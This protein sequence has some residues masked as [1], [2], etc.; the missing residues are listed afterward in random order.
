MYVNKAH[1]VSMNAQ[2]AEQL[3]VAKVA[4]TLSRSTEVMKLVR[5]S[6]QEILTLHINFRSK[7]YNTFCSSH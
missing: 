1:M 4:G 6:Y 7:P 2:L 3:G 5:P